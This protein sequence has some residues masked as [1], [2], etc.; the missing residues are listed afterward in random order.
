LAVPAADCELLAAAALLVLDED[1]DVEVAAVGDD[2]LLP[3]PPR[4]VVPASATIA[5]APLR[6][7]QL[8][9]EIANCCCSR[10]A[11]GTGRVPTKALRTRSREL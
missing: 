5:G 9:E 4:T 8:R 7:D 6:V 2:E 1:E 10:G 11:G 3:H